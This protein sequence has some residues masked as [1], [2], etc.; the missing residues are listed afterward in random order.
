MENYYE[1]SWGLYTVPVM[2]DYYAIVFMK[3]KGLV[4]DNAIFING[5]TGDFLTGGHIPHIQNKQNDIQILID[6]IIGKHHSLWE[7]LKTNKNLEAISEKILLNINKKH[8]S[9]NI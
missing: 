2:M 6:K 7:Q 4:P 9:K 8:Y 5:Q 1:Y 3:K